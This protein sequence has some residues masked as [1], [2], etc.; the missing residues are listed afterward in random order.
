MKFFAQ[1]FKWSPLFFGLLWLLGRTIIGKLTGPE[2]GMTYGALTNIF[3]ILMLVF[4][5]LVF[6]YKEVKERPSF[7]SDLKDA[8]RPALLYILTATVFIGLYYSVLSDDLV[9]M[10]NQ[11]IAELDF[12]LSTEE[13]VNELRQAYPLLKDATREQ[14]Y[15]Q[16]KEGIDRNLSVQGLMVGGIMLLMLCAFLYAL[17]AVF[18]WRTFVKRI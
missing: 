1:Y 18:F 2:Q 6:K 3:I 4:V 7:L 12:A 9:L 15:Q 11:K 13:K 10:R 8:L 17:L 5:A 16:S 14:I